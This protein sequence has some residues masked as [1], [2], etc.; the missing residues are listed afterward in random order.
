MT[1]V[2]PPRTRRWGAATSNAVRLLALR[3]RPITQVELA[4]LLGVRQPRVSQILQLLVSEGVLTSELT[5]ASQRAHMVDLYVRHHRPA[6]VSETLWYGLDPHLHQIEAV[7]KFLSSLGAKYVVSA[8][9]ASDYLAPW[10]SPSLTVIYAESDHRLQDAGL[11][12][13][14]ARGEATVLLR[15]ISDSSL[16]EPWPGRHD[17]PFPMAHPVQQIWDLHDLGGADRVEAAD[18]VTRRIAAS[19]DPARL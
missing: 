6:T 16:L 7:S 3:S 4:Q 18:R 15:E 19:D 12:A 17:A 10:R 13:A 9:A 1:T 8:D 11:V 14:M 5:E 2:E